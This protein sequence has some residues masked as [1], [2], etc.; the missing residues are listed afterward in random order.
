M[1]KL[2]HAIIGCGRI[3][4]N[5][6]NACKENDISVV[7][8]CDMEIASHFFEKKHIII[9]KPVS[10]K[11][12]KVLI[13]DL[14]TEK[15]VTVISQHRFDYLVNF[16][17]KLVNSGDL[18][19]ITLVNGKLQC[20]RSPE[21]YRDSY[22]RGTI[23]KEGGSTV[24]NQSY[25]IIDTLIY[26][27]GKPNRIYAFKNSFKYENIIETEDTCVAI[28]EYPN[29]LVSFSSTNTA[30]MDWS[31]NIEIIGT[32]GTISFTI[33]F[34]EVITEF[35]VNEKIKTKYIDEL[36]TI[37][38]NYNNNLNLAANYY[39]LS[40]NAQFKNFKNAIMGYESIRIGI[41]DAMETLSV[42]EEIY[43]CANS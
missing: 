34:P 28:F 30:V 17:R 31:T 15:I 2:S 43:R 5:H 13:E 38:R 26:L 41:E 39:G 25:H 23:D 10:T 24:I 16:V 18:G 29:M 27:F 8:C 22:W 40:H 11:C 20:Y 33:D 21:Y 7:C 36:Q 19:R 12:K 37:E 35:C 42:I 14:H 3:A 9:E 6:I 1:N 4:Q 32:E